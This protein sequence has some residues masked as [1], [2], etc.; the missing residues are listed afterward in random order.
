MSE[1]SD[2]TVTPYLLVPDVDD[3]ISFCVD[4]FEASELG[5]LTRPEGTVMHAEIVVRGSTIMLGE[6]MGEFEPAPGWIFV[7]VENCEA[8][9]ERALAAGGQSVMEVTEMHHA[10]ERYGGVRDSGGN[11]WW[12]STTTE[13]VPWREQQRRIDALVEQDLGR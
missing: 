12:I 2:A 6:P 10:G 11:V 9:Y 7:R 5:R 1:N 4:V 3:V 13:Q 8:V